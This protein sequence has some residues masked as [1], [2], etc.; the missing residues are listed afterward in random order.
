MI[1]ARRTVNKREL[2]LRLKAMRAARK[3]SQERVAQAVDR[4]VFTVNRWERGVKMPQPESLA[5]LAVVFGV[6]TDYLLYSQEAKDGNG[7]DSVAAPQA[8]R[9]EISRQDASE[10]SA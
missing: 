7:G 1:M 9:Q 8:P 2:G 5:N 6:T 4:S 3:W 10:Q